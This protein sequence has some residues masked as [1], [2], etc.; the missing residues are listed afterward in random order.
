MLKLRRIRTLPTE[1]GKDAP[2]KDGGKGGKDNG[3]DA[4][5]VAV[6]GNAAAA[7]NQTV[8]TEATNSTSDAAGNST[9]ALSESSATSVDFYL[10][11]K[12]LGAAAVVTGL[13]F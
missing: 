8:T 1:A 6:A 13:W 5:V 7:P 11:M 9:D 12:T 2:A 10:A 3:K 4:A